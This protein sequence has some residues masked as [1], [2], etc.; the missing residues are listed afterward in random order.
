MSAPRHLLLRFRRRYD[1]FRNDWSQ[2]TSS[3]RCAQYLI[4]DGYVQLRPASVFDGSGF[5]FVFDHA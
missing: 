1:F 3:S 2:H 4:H 5:L